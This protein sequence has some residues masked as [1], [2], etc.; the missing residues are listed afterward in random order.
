[1]RLSIIT[2][3][4]I[5]LMSLLSC[6]GDGSISGSYKATDVHIIADDIEIGEAVRVD[7]YFET[8]TDFVGRPDDVELVVQIGSA[9]RYQPGSSEIYDGN[10]DD[11]DDRSPDDVVRCADG[12]TFLLYRFDDDDLEDRSI[13]GSTGFGL[14]IH[15]VG[16]NRTSVARI[17][18]AAG[19]EQEFSCR[20][21]FN[22]ESSDSV[23]VTGLGD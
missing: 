1:M 17:E 7:V 8:K 4:S 5:A 11:T 13:F 6:G 20:D 19:E 14:R 16:E 22:S 23:E 21:D 15:V 18:A 12:R 2:G 10:T 3:M 9:L